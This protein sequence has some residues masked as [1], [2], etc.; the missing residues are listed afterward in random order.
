MLQLDG[1][2]DDNIDAGE[3]RLGWVGVDLEPDSLTCLDAGAIIVNA[4][5]VTKLLET[6]TVYRPAVRANC[7]TSM[8]Y[9]SHTAGSE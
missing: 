1:S 5:S 6:Y 3:E 2:L 9:S 7:E 4:S 8:T